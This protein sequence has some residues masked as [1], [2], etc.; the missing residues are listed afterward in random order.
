MK[1]LLFFTRKIVY[2]G[3]YVID[4]VL[5]RRKN[6]LVILCYHSISHD[7]WRF[8]ITMEN[9]TKQIEY[10]KEHFDVISLNDAKLYLKGLK[11]L[12]RPSVVITFDDGYQNVLSMADYLKKSRVTPTMFLIADADHANRRELENNLPL[13][14]TSEIEKLRKN[15]WEIGSHSLTH[16]NFK[17]L[18]KTQIT[19][20]VRNSK[21]ILEKKLKSKISYIAYPHGVYNKEIANEVINSGYEMG[22]SMDDGLLNPDSNMFALPRVG[23]D[24]SHSF[25]EFKATLLPSAITLRKLIKK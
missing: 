2:S 6:N 18:S 21:K 12:N 4:A 9:F 15:G 24:G 14:T 13:L 20:E 23:I 16:T 1:N 19:N 11:K 7:G 5:L 17:K 8:S 3:C 10:L 22:L 25:I